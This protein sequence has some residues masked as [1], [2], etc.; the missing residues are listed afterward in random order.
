MIPIALTL[1]GLYSY[2]GK[3][4][5]DFT[6]LTQDGLF[7][8]FG[9]VGSGK[10]S[11]LEAISFA[12]YEESER[13]NAREN[14]NYNMMNLKSNELL[15]DFE[16]RSNTDTIYRFVVRGKRNSK[17]FEDVR[18]FDRTAYKKE[19]DQWLPIDPKTIEEITGLNYKNFR[20]TIIIP[21]G[22]FQEFLQLNASDRTTMLKELFNLSKYELSDKV[23]RLET[24]NNAAVQRVQGQLEEVGEIKP[25]R[26][27]ELKKN[28]LE[29][30]VAIDGLKQELALSQQQ[31]QDLD[32][33]KVLSGKITEQTKVFGVLQNNQD[34]FELLEREVKVYESFSF[35]FK[36]DLEQ[37]K[38]VDFSLQKGI[39]ELAQNK[40]DQNELLKHSAQLKTA[41]EVL[42][43]EYDSRERLIQ[44]SEEIKKYVEVRKSKRLITSLTQRSEKGKSTLQATIN[45]IASKRLATKTND[46]E[47]NRLKQNPAKS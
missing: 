37:L 13:L 30:K 35:I 17:K 11:I 41:F 21:Q 26:I 3:Q 19:A 28:T 32:N 8:I 5:I 15:I 6:K 18:S 33:L 39:N 45:L 42:K 29:L 22:R 38:V 24:K 1:Q 10:S 46:E 44:E 7:G 36:S 20:R 9:S 40:N 47:L 23:A 4:I 43:I 25:E 34:S 27:A 12:L 31:D 14:R 16:F 2:R